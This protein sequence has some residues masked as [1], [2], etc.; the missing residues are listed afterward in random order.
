MDALAEHHQVR[1]IAPIPWTERIRVGREPML[2]SSHHTLVVHPTFYYPPRMLRGTYGYWYW[3]SIRSTVRR[4]YRSYRPDV[5]LGYW[6]HPDGYGALQGAKCIGVPVVNMVGGSDV[7]LLANSGMRRAAIQSVLRRSDRVIAF[8]RDLAAHVVDLGVSRDRVEVVYR[9]VDRDIFHPSDRDQ[10]R[11]ELILDR[12][13]LI[14]LWVG[15]LVEVKNP[16]MA[17]RGMVRWAQQFGERV[18]LI[19]VGDGPLR[20]E[21]ESLAVQL[22]VANHCRFVGAIPH[23]QLATWFQAA[24][25][26]LLTSRSEGVPNVLIESVA[27]GTPFVATDV[28]GVREIAHPDSDRLVDSGDE[29]GLQNSV[30]AKLSQRKVHPKQDSTYDIH[31]LAG[32]VSDILTRLTTNS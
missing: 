22:G 23:E 25:V 3:H 7:R 32:R 16:H 21:L 24:D 19:L 10:A 8:S 30:I 13:R 17:L 14:I 26:T 2:A 29:V 6:A 1:V 15:R 5:V 20:S 18:Q 12:S 9:G 11:S 28:G 31:G 27:C 4:M